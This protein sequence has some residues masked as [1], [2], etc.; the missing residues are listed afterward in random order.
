MAM[1]KA[2]VLGIHSFLDSGV[3][4][5]SQ[6]IAEGLA[7]RGWKV[8]YISFPSSPFDCYGQA[9]RKRFRR[10]WMHHQD[11]RGI[12]INANLTEYAFCTLYPA[13]K[14][15]LRNHLLMAAYPRL[16]P[17]WLRMRR[18]DVC[19]NDI[20][21]NILFLPFIRSQLFFLRLNDSPEGF[22]HDLHQNLINRFKDLIA[23]RAYHEI[24]AVSK[25]LADYALALNAENSLVVLPNGVDACCTEIPGH[26]N[27]K[28]RSAVFIGSIARWVDLELLEKTAQLMPEWQF[29]I[30]GP[31]DVQWECRTRNLS[32]FP[33]VDR[34]EV[35]KLLNSYQVGL[36]PFRESPSLMEFIEKPLKFYEYISAGL[37]VASTDVGELRSGMGDLAVF[38]N[39]PRDYAKAIEQ[40]AREGRMRSAGF[41]RTFMNEHSWETILENISERISQLQNKAPLNPQR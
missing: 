7:K 17:A 36:I 1:K 39:T 11:K 41:I 6:Y 8:D 16:A 28:P 35:P 9:R 14:M 3:K 40:A 19:I 13:H 26:V 20:T 27:R 2:I 34:T 23:S 22:A 29:H 12:L 10:V 21:T 24:W 30:Y 25:P 5:G 31:L 4:V 33:P 38:G 15:F 18:Y 32:C 37:G